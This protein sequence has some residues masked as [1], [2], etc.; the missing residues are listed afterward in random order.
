MYRS[1]NVHVI[2]KHNY[3]SVETYIWINGCYTVGYWTKCRWIVIKT[4]KRCTDARFCGCWKRVFS[5][6]SNKLTIDMIVHEMK[7]KTKNTTPF[8]TVPKSKKAKNTTPFRT[9]PKSNRKQKIPH[10]LELFQ[11]LKKNK[12]YHTI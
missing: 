5:I 8:R 10:H 1:Q 2:R 4:R 7:W 9:V 3:F 12:K 6:V 11:N